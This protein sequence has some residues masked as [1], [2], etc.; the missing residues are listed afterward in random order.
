MTHSQI[1]T[2]EADKN[3]YRPTITYEETNQGQN[4]G[5]ANSNGYS[6]NGQFQG[7]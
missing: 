2:Y 5:Y 6:N 7:Y 4:N 3:G 1:V